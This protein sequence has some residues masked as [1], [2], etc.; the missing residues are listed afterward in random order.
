MKANEK[1]CPRCAEVIKKDALVCKHCGHEFSAAEIEQQREKEAAGRKNGAIGCLGIIALLIAVGMC[2]ESDPDEGSNTVEPVTAVSLEDAKALE[3]TNAAAIATKLQEARALPASDAAANARVYGEL[4]TL[5]PANTEYSR[6]R[7][8]YAAIVSKA[9][10]EASMYESNPETALELE[11]FNWEKGGFGSVQ[12]VRFTVRNSAPFDIKDFELTCVHQGG[13]GTD[14]DRNVR[15][16]Y[17]RVPANGT[18]RVG[19]MN[20]GLINSQVATSH[21]EITDAVRA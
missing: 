8:E 7:D 10:R 19:E 11:N 14:M 12:L 15:V 1:A 2:S 6:K 21:C 5:A 17:E 18:K 13:S 20:M 16:V 9:E 3:K 4:V